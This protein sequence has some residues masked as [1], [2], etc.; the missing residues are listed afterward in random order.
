MSNTSKRLFYFEDW[1]DPAG[2]E[3]ASKLEGVELI[4]M[5]QS[6]NE[7]RIWETLATA[8]GYQMRAS[9]E[10]QKRFWPGRDFL[11]RCPNLLAISSAGA[12][13]DM[14]DVAA[15]TEAGI[16]VV[17]QSG[18]NA[19]SVAQHVFG[20]MLTLC[21]QMI[22]SDR[23]IRREG[24][25][26]TRWTYTGH[27][28]TG[29]TIG[30][31]GLGNIGRRVAEISKAF[32]MRAFAYDPYITDEDFRE[33]GAERVTS[34]EELF[35]RVDF[36]SINCPLTDETNGMINADLFGRMKQSAIFITTARGYIH[37]ENA[38]ADV[39]SAG[40]IA[41]AGCD[42]FEIEPPIFDHPLMSFDNVIVSPHNA[43]ITTDAAYNMA[44]Y[45]AEQWGDIFAGR[46]PPRLRNPDVWPRYRARFAEMFGVE[47]QAA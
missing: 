6:E 3:V 8:H 11:E 31:V 21:K 43:G 10:T 47:P 45:A 12:G 27:E 9:T 17:S 4:R 2:V 23:A 1:M 41:A 33:R 29:R 44:T 32:N 19:E 22:Q 28:L 36:I 40:R 30:I 5:E 15:C 13:Y 14:A 25:D 46:Y 24:R 16:A 18:S 34:L 26:W 42:V 39:L 38:L 7:D 35:E 37:D 20:M